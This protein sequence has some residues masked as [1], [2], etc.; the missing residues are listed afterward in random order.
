M[1]TAPRLAALGV[2]VVGAALGADGQALEV[3]IVDFYGLSQVTADE[4]RR[5]LTFKEGDTIDLGDGKYPAVFKS[6]EE[7][8]AKLPGVVGARIEP[9]CCDADRVIVYV[10]IQERGASTLLLRPAPGG[11]ARLPA[12]IATA[13]DEFSRA[14]TSA[15]Q[16]GEAREDR[17]QGHSLMDDPATRA[18]QERFIGLANRHLEALRLV[19]R[20]S[21]A[22]AERALAAQVMAYT[23]DKQSV[24][25]DLVRAMSDPAGE[26]RNS[27]MRSLMVFAEALPGPQ[28]STV[29]VPVE[30]FIGFLNSPVW[31]DRNKS[32]LALMALSARRDE[33][34]LAA[35][36]NA[37][38]PPLV[39]MARWKSAG[40]AQPA[41]MILARMAGYSDEVAGG[42][43]E[44][45]DRETVI[46]AAIRAR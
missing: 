19:L 7:R 45:G 43:W 17:T 31:S 1:R 16:R 39:E 23:A 21:S 11:T 3:G 5:A 46:E 13:G 24:V 38:L 15:V 44:R 29:R 22:A 8:L 9:V 27:A 41:F 2:L 6:S 26:V 28:G 4:A 32:S 35:L 18:V 20:D 25:D 36:R 33:K 12:E 37:A 34:V 40:H 10:G 30:P 14:F 42:L